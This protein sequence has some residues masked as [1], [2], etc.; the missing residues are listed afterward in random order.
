M[1]IEKTNEICP[2]AT[3]LKPKRFL[4]RLLDK[5][6]IRQAPRLPGCEKIK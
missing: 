4:A 2:A 5:Q 1:A 3:S 6:M